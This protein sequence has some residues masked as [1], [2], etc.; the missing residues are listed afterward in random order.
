MHNFRG[1]TEREWTIFRRDVFIVPVVPE[2]EVPLWLLK[3]FENLLSFLS[4]TVC[5]L[6]PDSNVPRNGF[7]EK[8]LKNFTSLFVSPT[9]LF[10]ESIYGTRLGNALIMH[11]YM[12]TVRHTK[13]KERQYSYTT[14]LNFSCQN[15]TMTYCLQG[16]CST[17]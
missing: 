15:Q 8:C 9:E 11:G 6:Y 4:H 3:M 12:E 7:P 14:N 13:I 10:P 17:D 1:S 5:S 2:R 16:R